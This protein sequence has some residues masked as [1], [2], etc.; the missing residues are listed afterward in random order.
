MQIV[1]NTGWLKTRVQSHFMITE[2]AFS[3]FKLCGNVTLTN[4]VAHSKV[5]FVTKVDF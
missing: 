1:S 5:L 4:T 3:Y 2:A